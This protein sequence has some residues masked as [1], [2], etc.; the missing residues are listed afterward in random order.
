MEDLLLDVRYALRVLCESPAFTIVA[1]FLFAAHVKA[2][3]DDK[4]EIEQQNRTIDRESAVH[5][6]DI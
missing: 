1:F 6:G 5:V 4:N 3:G 2:D